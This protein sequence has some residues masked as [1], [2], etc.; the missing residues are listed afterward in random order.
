MPLKP[1]FDERS[2]Y[3]IRLMRQQLR[4]NAMNP[5][6]LLQG[7]DD[8][9]QQLQLDLTRIRQASAIGDV[10]VADHSLAAFVYEEGIAENTP[11]ID[12][13]ITRKDFGID[14][15]ED[16]LRGTGIVPR[17][18]ARP[19]LRLVIEQGTQ[20]QGRK[21]PEVEDF[22]WAPAAAP[23]AHS[24]RDRSEIRV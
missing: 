6:R 5:G 8:V 16:H 22:Q 24:G 14:I 15:A 9:G 2:G 19:E 4:F 11:A 23:L 13:G 12:C 18:Q 10:Q 3:D 21:S 20:I 1:G 7:F 17:K